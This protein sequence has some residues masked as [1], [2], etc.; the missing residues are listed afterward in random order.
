MYIVSIN[1]YSFIIF[2]P[3][4]VRCLGFDRLQGFIIGIIDGY[5]S[6]FISLS[7]WNVILSSISSF[8]LRLPSS[9]S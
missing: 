6:I 5:W 2:R 3:C 9:L 1:L 8:S 4:C 7:I